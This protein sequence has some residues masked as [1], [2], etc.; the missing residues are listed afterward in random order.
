M[1]FWQHRLRKQ[2]LGLWATVFVFLL[3][4]LAWS[5]M[6]VYAKNAGQDWIEVCTRDGIKRISLPAAAGVFAGGA[7]KEAPAPSLGDH[8]DLCVVAKGLGRATD[9]VQVLEGHT[10]IPASRIHTSDHGVPDKPH[11]PQQPRA[12]PVLQLI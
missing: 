6:P 3:Q 8:C 9:A 12:P 4:S 10:R 2:R 11:S 5:G 1:T 7:L